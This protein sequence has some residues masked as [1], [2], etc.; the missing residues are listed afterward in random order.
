ASQDLAAVDTATLERAVGELKGEFLEDLSLPRCPEFEA[1]R[2]AQVDEANLMRASLLRALIDRFAAEPARALPYAHALQAMDPASRGVAA[3]VQALAN[4]AREQAGRAPR[5]STD[6]P[7]H[8]ELSSA[9]DA[10]ERKHVTVLAIDIVS[11]LHAFASV[12]PDVALAHMDPL[13]ELT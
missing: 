2:V 5:S 12:A 9:G 1:W 10:A 3:E 4:R 7:G 11:P 13:F 6:T 8:A